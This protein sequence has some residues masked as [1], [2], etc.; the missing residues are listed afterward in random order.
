MGPETGTVREDEPGQPSKNGGGAPASAVGGMTVRLVIPA[1]TASS[2]LPGKLLA[3]VHGRPVLEWTWR[4]AVASGAGEVLIAAADDEILTAA[5]AFGARAVLVAGDMA[6]G[7][8]RLAALARRER[9]PAGDLIVN[10]QGDEPLL[11]AACLSQIV[12][13]AA[14]R[15]EAVWSLYTPITEDD[16]VHDPAVVKV[17]IGE[18]GRAL[19]FSRAAIPHPAAGPVAPGGGLW[20]RHIGLYAY[21]VRQLLDFAALPE[22]AIERCEALEQLRLLAHG[23]PLCLAAAAAP[24]PPGI[25]TARDLARLRALPPECFE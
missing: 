21:R 6:S 17:V 3:D 16:E 7:T 5:L 4:R 11:P 23:R 25:D 9:W 24:V 10:L 13:L 19:Y 1:R 14:D 18:D 15:P 8:E 20:R 12:R 22:V 2:R